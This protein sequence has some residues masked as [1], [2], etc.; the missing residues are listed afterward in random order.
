MSL[1]KEGN[2][3]KSTTQYICSYWIEHR[4]LQLFILPMNH[5]GLSQWHNHLELSNA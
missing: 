2:K 3:E 1:P 5:Q 4:Q